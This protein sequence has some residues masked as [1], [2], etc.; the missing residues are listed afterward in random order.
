MVFKFIWE[1]EDISIEDDSPSIYA[2]YRIID[3]IA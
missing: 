3:S 1:G 2:F